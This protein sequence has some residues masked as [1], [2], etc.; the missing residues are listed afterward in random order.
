MSRFLRKLMLRPDRDRFRRELAEELAAHE[1][2]KYDEHLR[3]GLHP[4]EAERQTRLDMGNVTSA[5]EEA[6]DVR[7][8][9]W[10]RYMRD[11]SYAFRVLRK[12]AGF[13]LLAIL[14]L[15]LGIG[16]ST[17]VFSILNTLLIRP[18][19]F[20]D[21]D[22]LVRITEF[23]PK[24]LQVHLRDRC[25]SMDIASVSPGLEMNI[26]GQGP[27]YRVKASPVSANLFTVLRVP[28]EYGRP[29]EQDEDQ[30]GRDRVVI[31]SHGLWSQQF[32]SDPSAVGRVVTLDGVQ[33][34]IVG[35]MPAGFA[36]PSRAVQLWLPATID[37]RQ[38]VDYWAG[39]FTPLI[40]RLRPGYTAEQA[41]SEL[42][43]LLAGV[44]QMFPWPMPRHWNANATVISLQTDM[45]GD[46][47][48]RLW[49]LLCSVGV[50]L[51][52]ACANV[53]GLLTVRGAT[54]SKEL[55]MRAAVG[56]GRR[57]HPHAGT[58]HRAGQV[59]AGCG[60]QGGG[61]PHRRP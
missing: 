46:A 13:S 17:A 9:V 11:I 35:I 26:T 38:T 50:V 29:F 43:P 52:I 12:N 21:P 27:A 34:T 39:E 5:L 40:A 16:G 42:K 54:R 10:E 24:A 51:V 8:F 6:T 15:A 36:F 18:L 44:W 41:R 28:V 56:A 57:E 53:A 61:L 1:A 48:G 23:F 20:G 32:H 47:P 58:E 45:A 22:R 30:P 19:P 60:P 49:L 25:R 3:A 2:L 7:A 55:A 37:P 4:R 59:R 31:L 33:R 14:S